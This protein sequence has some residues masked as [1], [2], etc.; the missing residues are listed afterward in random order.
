MSDINVTLKP[1]NGIRVVLVPPDETEVT[2]NRM[3]LYDK[4]VT[5]GAKDWA[6][7]TDGMVQEG[8]EDVDYSSKA[9]AI[10][11]VGT[12]TNNAKYY[13]EQ[14]LAV[15]E[16]EN[17]AA[18]GEDLRSQDSAI[19]TVNNNITNIN[20]VGD[21][22]ESINSVSENIED[23]NTVS[24]NIDAIQ[25]L[26]E[27]APYLVPIGE[28][29]NEIDVVATDLSGENNVGTVA[30]NISDVNAV[31]GNISNVNSVANNSTNINA[32]NSN[33]SNIDTVATNI[34]DIGD[35]ADNISAVVAVNANE[36]NIN[37]VNS[38]K[39][40]IDDVAT[41]SSDIP[42]VANIAQDVSTVAGIS[43]SVSSVAGNSTNI[44]TVAGISSSVQTV[45]GISQDVSSVSS[46]TSEIE[47]CADNM[48]DIQEASIYGVN[49]RKWAEGT[50]QEVQE[51]GGTASA[52]DWAESDNVLDTTTEVI[53][54][55]K[56][57]A[58]K[59]EYT[60]DRVFYFIDDMPIPTQTTS[61]DE[62]FPKWAYNSDGTIVTTIRSGVAYK[63]QILSGTSS[64]YYFVG[65]IDGNTI[66]GSFFERD[67][68]D[69]INATKRVNYDR[70]TF[71]T[72]KESMLCYEYALNAH[73]DKEKAGVWA[74]GDDNSVQVLGGT[75]SAKGWAEVAQSAAEEVGDFGGATAQTDGH[76]GLVIKPYAG[77]QNK[78]LKGDGSWDVVIPETYV[79]EQGV[80]SAEWTINHNLNKFPSVSVVD[81][82]GNEI[83]ADVKYDSMNTCIIR[84]TGA[85]KGKA[86]LN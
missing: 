51:I 62:H 69:D 11:G 74:E 57:Y 20:A 38:N 54:V 76:R 39:S 33:K 17:V 58:W 63:W 85:S 4:T 65:F 40:N 16:D 24:D 30:S 80:A 60:E 27:A 43:S 3:Y 55:N 72:K 81:S 36:A 70:N 29:L 26:S 48:Q 28:H 2:L 32:V 7:K 9:Y 12:E 82:A 1:E 23:V 75:H 6:V 52:K 61:R 25:D 34:S 50:Q 44:N 46:I 22:L 77:D 13:S 41:I 53:T 67:E 10:G 15:L 79:H 35:V 19:K 66:T 49:A 45:A 83:I 78:F 59:D 86:F 37:A 68:P 47:I 64:G 31:G 84:M 14:A 8:G 71:S 56:L 18:V 21:N 42:T 73:N 5:D